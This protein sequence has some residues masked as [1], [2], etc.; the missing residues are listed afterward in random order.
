MA[1]AY[2]HVFMTFERMEKILVQIAHIVKDPSLAKKRT[3]YYIMQEDYQFYEIYNYLTVNFETQ[4]IYL[5]KHN[6]KS[7]VFYRAE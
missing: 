6:I 5:A 2:S 7:L 3:L 4:I 1:P